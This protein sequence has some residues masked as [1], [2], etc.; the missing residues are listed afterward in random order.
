[1]YTHS[2]LQRHSLSSL[3][4][5]GKLH[6]LKGYSSINKNNR[7]AFELEVLRKQ[8]L[9][10]FKDD[11]ALRRCATQFKA[12]SGRACELAVIADIQAHRAITAAIHTQQQ[13]EHARRTIDV[14]NLLAGV[15]APNQCVDALSGLFN[16]LLLLAIATGQSLLIGAV[17]LYVLLKNYRTIPTIVKSWV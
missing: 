6:G 2:E 5:L 14:D 12:F 13:K 11:L 15:A 3:K 17:W 9:Q 8:G 10:A 16:L 7:L 4:K 1:M